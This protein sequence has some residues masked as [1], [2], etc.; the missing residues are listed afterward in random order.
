MDR[1]NYG[2]LLIAE[3]EWFLPMNNSSYKAFYGDQSGS[4]CAPALWLT[5]VTAQMNF[6]PDDGVYSGNDNWGVIDG[7]GFLPSTS[8]DLFWF[9]DDG[10]SSFLRASMTDANGAM[11]LATLNVTNVKTPT[12]PNSS[13]HLHAYVSGHGT[14]VNYCHAVRFVP[15]EPG[16]RVRPIPVSFPVPSNFVINIAGQ[17]DY[18]FRGGGD[19]DINFT[20]RPANDVT[21]YPQNGLSTYDNLSQACQ[22]QPTGNAQLLSR[23]AVSSLQGIALTTDAGDPR[24]VFVQETTLSR[25]TQWADT[26]AGL[27]TGGAV[28]P[29]TTA[30]RGTRITKVP[31]ALIAVA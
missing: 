12:Q 4:C 21:G 25:H 2:L 29:L 20:P 6:T 17:G 22:G 9:N 7:S 11:P 31:C 8:Y 13:G 1:T 15:I 18:L 26:R 10:S 24:H 28:D 30:V 23:P 19:T 5:Y 14:D 16:Q 3:N 27:A